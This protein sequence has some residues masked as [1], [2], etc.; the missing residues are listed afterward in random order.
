MRSYI[1]FLL[2]LFI[3]GSGLALM[4]TAVNP[5]VTI[6]GPIESA[7]K[8][9]SIMGICN[10]IAGILAPLILATFVLSGT[11][12]I[13]REIGMSISSDRINTL[14]DTMAL[15]LVNP[16]IA[17]TVVLLLLGFLIRFTHLPKLTKEK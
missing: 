13:S 3:L 17:M 9:I 1:L 2:G 15:R 4:Q 8:R 7:A 16:Y 11:E 14:L 6:L 12:E 10:K 5:Y